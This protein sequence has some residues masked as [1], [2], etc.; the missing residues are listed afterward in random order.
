MKQT[1]LMSAV[2][3]VANVTV[4]YGLAVVTQLI[5]FPWFGYPS[6][7]RDSLAIGLIFT[8]V[9]LVRSFVLRRAFEGL[10]REEC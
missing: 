4:G 9:S 2:E 8:V 5:V 10:R 3:S 1:K 7:L 6:V